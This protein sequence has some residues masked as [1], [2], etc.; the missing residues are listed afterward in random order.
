MYKKFYIV[1]SLINILLIGLL[2]FY[3]FFDELNYVITITALV[4]ILQIIF[5]LITKY[6]FKKEAVKIKNNMILNAIMLLALW[7]GLY[8]NRFFLAVSWISYVLA[9][10]LAYREAQDYFE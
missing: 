3:I 7:A 2:C 9:E 4:I 5:N 1:K 6:K 10:V 8:F